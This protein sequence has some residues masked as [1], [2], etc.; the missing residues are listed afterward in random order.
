MIPTPRVPEP[1]DFNQR[2][3]Q[4]GLA[5]LR[6][7]PQAN[8]PRDY[9]SPYR[10]DLQEGQADLCAYAAMPAIPDGQIDHFL[11][12]RNH[13]HL[14]YEWS[15]YRF[16][17]ALMNNRKRNH[18]DAILDPWL[19]EDGWFEILLPSLQLVGTEQIPAQL[20]EKA[21]FTLI[22]LGLRD[23]E[24][25]IRWRQAFYEQYLNGALSLQGLRRWAPLLARAIE[26][27]STAG[28]GAI[29]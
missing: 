8:R 9:W 13:P 6:D 29:Y 1:E 15:N 19:V 21:Q 28:Q 3:R 2:A 16:A 22:Q 5:W 12:F 17:S 7:H 4:P 26:R 25:I 10:R 24:R 20:R 14:A 23:D 18:D 27:Q 11:S